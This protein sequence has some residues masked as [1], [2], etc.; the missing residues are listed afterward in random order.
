MILVE[1]YSLEENFKLRKFQARNAQWQ[2]L[3]NKPNGALW[4]SPVNSEWGW[5]HW[6]EAESFGIKPYRVEFTLHNDSNIYLVDSVE[7][8]NDLPWFQPL[9]NFNFILA[10]DVDQLI[11]RGYDGLWL[12]RKGEMDTR[13]SQPMTMY[14]WDCET[15]CLFNHHPIKLINGKEPIYAQDTTAYP[16]GTGA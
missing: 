13:F 14:G 16:V 2:G 7:E 3:C 4:T 9:S 1:H 6:C 12:T 15:I 10:L 8:C 11:D 5:R